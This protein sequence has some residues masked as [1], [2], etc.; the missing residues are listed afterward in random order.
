M[1]FEMDELKK[2]ARRM[3]TMEQVLELVPV[4]KSTLKRMIKNGEFPSAHYISPKK[5]VWY[6]D[7][8]MLWQ[9]D[10]PAESR[11]KRA[12]RRAKAE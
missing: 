6:E 7:S 12:A 3:L 11:S 4:G 2:G 10:L 1:V 9:E 5:L 8:I